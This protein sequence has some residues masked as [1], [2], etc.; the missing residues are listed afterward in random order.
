MSY[1]LRIWTTLEPKPGELAGA[2]DVPRTVAEGRGW[3]VNASQTLHVSAEDIPEEIANALPGIAYLIELNL[4]PADAPASARAKLGRLA[5][6]LA[7]A[8]HGVVED[9]QADSLT[10]GTRVRR[11]SALGKSEEATILKMGFWYESG[12]M[13]S[14]A[15]AADLL[16]LLSRYLPEAVPA[17]YGEFE[18]PQFRL[19]RDG[20]P[21]LTKFMRQHWREMAV[22]Y[23]S[24]PVAHVHLSHP[25]KIGPSPRGYRSGHFTIEIDLDAL[26]Q[27]GWR[28]AVTRAWRELVRFVQPFYADI[29][30]LQHY[31]RARGRYWIATTTEHHPVC[32]WWWSGVPAGAVYA[33]A[34]GKPYID[35]WPEFGGAAER[36]GSAM[37][38]MAA[39]WQAGAPALKQTTIPPR[40]RQPRPE[41]SFDPDRK[42][43]A[44]WPF[45]PPRSKR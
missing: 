1:D 8:C 16:D 22:Y 39:D 37:V 6:Q 21:A 20:R 25:E 23:P 33:M 32:S 24:P 31:T 41:F 7:T 10:L 26:Q 2:P 18:P 40:I 42:Y 43:P 35:L 12:P 9:P 19:D 13:T 28:V 14:D 36:L 44:E 17:R 38:Q 4:E 3:L 11:L 27:P 5:K 45:A 29:R 15:A 30:H 34:L